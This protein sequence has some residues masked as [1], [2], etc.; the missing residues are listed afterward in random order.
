MKKSTLLFFGILCLAQF[1]EAQI[2]KGTI[3]LG[4]QI[5]A[6]TTSSEIQLNDYRAEGINISPS[7]GIAFRENL[8][9]GLLGS[10]GIMNS[11]SADQIDRTYSA[12]AFIRKYLP[13]GHSF[14]L[15]GQSDLVFHH[16]RSESE[17]TDNQRVIRQNGVNLNLFPGIAYGIHK[18]LQ[19]EMGLNKMITAGYNHIKDENT[20]LAGTS[21]GY[22]RSAYFSTN[23]SAASELYVGFR[24]VIGQ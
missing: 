6:F 10:Y 15:F 18:N 1:S 23:F 9:T 12:G 17:S 21:T 13:L 5:S 14:Y 22:S 7:V 20:S 3:L 8:V 24:V 2:K 19:L 11:K 4:G 16:A